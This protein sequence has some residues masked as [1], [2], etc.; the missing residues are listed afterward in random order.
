M[1]KFL[2]FISLMIIPYFGIT[3]NTIEGNYC[4]ETF[5]FSNDINYFEFYADGFFEYRK[6]S[7][8][9]DYRAIGTYVFTKDSIFLS[10]SKPSQNNNSPQLISESIIDTINNY[11]ILQLLDS[12]NLH[13]HYTFSYEIYYQDKIVKTGISDTNGSLTFDPTT[14]T[15][16]QIIT[17]R[18]NTTKWESVKVITIPIEPRSLSYTYLIGSPLGQYNFSGHSVSFKVKLSH[19]KKVLKIFHSSPDFFHPSVKRYTRYDLCD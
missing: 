10:F 19:Q 3:Q 9:G 11:S 14:G 12:N 17:Q 2:V 18:V 8:F 15:H 4:E 6:E 5:M 16:I 7:D 1:A 13:H